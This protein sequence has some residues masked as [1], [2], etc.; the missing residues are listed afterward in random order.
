MVCLPTLNFPGRNI[1]VLNLL[2]GTWART[3]SPSMNLTFPVGDGGRFDQSDHLSVTEDPV[4]ESGSDVLCTGGW[5]CQGTWISAPA[6][7]NCRR[8]L[9]L[10]KSAQA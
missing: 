7:L 1:A 5:C 2:N 3:R 9:S 8:V 10:V 4:P 6:L